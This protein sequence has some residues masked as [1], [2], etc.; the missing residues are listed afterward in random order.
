MVSL[1]AMWGHSRQSRANQKYSAHQKQNPSVP[2]S[3]TQPPELWEITVCSLKPPGLQYFVTLAWA[4]TSLKENTVQMVH[5]YLQGLEQLKREGPKDL[6][7]CQLIPQKLGAWCI[8]G[9]SKPDTTEDEAVRLTCQEFLCDQRRCRVGAGLFHGCSMETKM[10]QTLITKWKDCSLHQTANKPRRTQGSF[11][12]GWW[13]AWS[14]AV[15]LKVLVRFCY[16]KL[17]KG[18]AVRVKDTWAAVFFIFWKSMLWI[19]GRHSVRR[20]CKARPAG[21]EAAW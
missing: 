14:S 11:Q 4:Q 9:K 19:P 10:I 1:S 12:P 16:C 8:S 18:H 5:W 6:H 13:E 3:G 17:W 21:A 2:W 15:F 7:Y 20:N